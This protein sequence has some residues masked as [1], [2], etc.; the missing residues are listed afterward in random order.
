P[1]FDGLKAWSIAKS[2]RFDDA[3]ALLT[4]AARLAKE[5]E[6]QSEQNRV[7]RHL[8]L[9]YLEQGKINES[10]RELQLSGTNAEGARARATLFLAYASLQAKRDEDAIRYLSTLTGLSQGSF[11]QDM[12]PGQLATRYYSAERPWDPRLCLDGAFVTNQA[13][14]LDKQ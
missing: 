14:M 7:N 2:G 4:N 3:A 13:R 8:G 11:N 12:C 1:E 6:S 5:R 9:L 10:I